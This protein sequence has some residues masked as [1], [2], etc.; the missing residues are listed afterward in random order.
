MRALM[1]KPPR[2]VQIASARHHG[3]AVRIRFSGK[4][5]ELAELFADGLGFPSGP[6]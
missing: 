3:T 2:L 6:R 1:A 5:N 4:V